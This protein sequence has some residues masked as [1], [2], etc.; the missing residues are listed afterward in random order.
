MTPEQV[1]NS[2]LEGDKL[3]KLNN[4]LS[5]NA[6]KKT[7]MLFFQAVGKPITVGKKAT[8][9][10]GSNQGS[11]QAGNHQS[12]NGNNG[13]SGGGVKF[14]LNANTSNNAST[15]ARKLK[16]RKNLLVTDGMDHAMTG[17]TIILTKQI[18]S[19]KLDWK[20]VANQITT[21]SFNNGDDENLLDQG[22]SSENPGATGGVEN[23]L[24]KILIPAIDK[25]NLN[26]WQPYV[27]KKINGR[28]NRLIDKDA[29]TKAGKIKDQTVMKLNKFLSN[30][31][32]A[33]FTT[34]NKL[35]FFRYNSDVDWK[36]IPSSPDRIQMIEWLERMGRRVSMS[37]GNDDQK[38]HA[39][40]LQIIE[41]QVLQWAKTIQDVLNE[42][43][44]MRKENTKMTGPAIELQEWKERY[45]GFAH[46]IEQIR[47]EH[48]ITMTRAALVFHK[49]KISS[50][51]NEVDGMLTDA[52][53]MAMDN[54]R[55]LYS[56]EKFWQPLYGSDMDEIG[57]G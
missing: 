51:F 28:E 15:S 11:A 24:Q 45:A 32:A 27:P 39:M 10:D 47:T 43:S 25:S 35:T 1:E 26:A 42:A 46:L 3:D 41:N 34:E 13:G 7:F 53:N 21:M 22:L 18:Q 40:G 55:F 4:F 37:T 36:H 38:Y 9:R 57:V 16:S 31:Q 14:D 12:G 6:V 33:R 20:N 44:R 29:D 5:E 8:L 49:S 19:Q 54:V 48:R 56:L 52:N 2:M 50:V 23:I 17:I 30:L